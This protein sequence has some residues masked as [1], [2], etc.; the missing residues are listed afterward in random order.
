MASSEINSIISIAGDVCIDGS[1]INSGEFTGATITC[2][3]IS[4][5]TVSTI[6]N[7]FFFP[8]EVAPFEHNFPAFHE[9]QKMCEEY[10]GLER[11]Y[12]NFKTAYALVEQDW[13]G[14]KDD[15]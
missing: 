11:A 12:E 5:W 7:D 3:D 14:K 1:S 10:P 6:N 9:V 2:S 13:K 8:G 4:N 15:K